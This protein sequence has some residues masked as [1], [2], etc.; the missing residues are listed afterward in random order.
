[1]WAA[2]VGVGGQVLGYRYA[3]VY[4]TAYVVSSMSIISCP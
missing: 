4:R 1:M 3:N 2:A